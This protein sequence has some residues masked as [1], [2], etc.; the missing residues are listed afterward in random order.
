MKLS[1]F[2]PGLRTAAESS[3]VTL[4][5]TL[6][7]FAA[8]AAV[9]QVTNIC[10]IVQQIQRVQ[11]IVSFIV[12]I[13]AVIILLYAG[14]LFLTAGGNEERLKSA[15]GYLLYGIIGIAV[16]LLA[17]SAVPLIKNFIGGGTEF[18]ASCPTST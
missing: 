18:E 1:T 11:R 7:P 2:L 14:F 9:G 5:L 3:A 6:A 10:Q 8:R 16:A 13:I 12:G 15:K 17:N 4:A